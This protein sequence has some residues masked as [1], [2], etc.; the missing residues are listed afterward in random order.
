MKMQSE[1]EVR[2]SRSEAKTVSR[3]SAKRPR[4]RRPPLLTQIRALDCWPW[5]EVGCCSGRLSHNLLSEPWAGLSRASD[6]EACGCGNLVRNINTRLRRTRI[7]T[8]MS[9]VLLSPIF[10]CFGFTNIDACSR[11]FYP[12]R[13]QC[14][15]DGLNKSFTF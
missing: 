1:Q 5:R 8:Y 15:R 10:H 2:L 6:R 11:C 9:V 4:P 14:I 13:L 7:C 3:S 12:N